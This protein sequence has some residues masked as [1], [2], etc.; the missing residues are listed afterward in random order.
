VGCERWIPGDHV[1]VLKMSNKLW[2]SYAPSFNRET[3]PTCAIRCSRHC[4]TLRVT[5][6]KYLP[7]VQTVHRFVLFSLVS[8]P[9]L[10]YLFSI[11]LLSPLRTWYDRK[12]SDASLPSKDKELWVHPCKTISS[13]VLIGQV[14]SVVSIVLCHRLVSFR[15]IQTTI[16]VTTSW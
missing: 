1:Q 7:W 15:P 12:A 11:G 3:I 10:A 8:L 9:L 4:F 6:A 16:W 2:K 13:L 14:S 5:W